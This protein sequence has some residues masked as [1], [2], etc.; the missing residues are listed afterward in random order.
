MVI[1]VEVALGLLLVG[2]LISYLMR[3]RREAER[4]EITKRRVDAYMQTIR[5]EADNP[6]LMAMSDDEL[7]DLLL[8]S[9]HNLRQQD[10]R[11]TYLLFGGTIVAFAA[12]LIVATEEGLRGFGIALLI[13]AMVLYGINE[14]LTR[15]TRGPLVEKGIDVERLRVE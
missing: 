14:Y 1:L 2:F 6:Q 3:G 8:S 13:A 11:R 5:R 15:R 10:E 4:T 9:A 7:R 12:A